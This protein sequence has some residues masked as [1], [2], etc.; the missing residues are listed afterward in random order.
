MEMRLEELF[1][2]FQEAAEHPGKLK[3]QYI[4]QGKKVIAC[5]PYYV[6]EEL[7]FAAGMVPMG[8]WGCQ[9]KGILPDVFLFGCSDGDG[10]G[11]ER[12]AGRHIRGC[13][14]EHL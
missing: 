6:P 3:D 5:F 8:L 2:Y 14:P 1:K 7:I 11:T 12:N 4:R 10:D 13:L 9:G